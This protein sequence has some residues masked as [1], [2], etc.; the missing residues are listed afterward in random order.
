M[1]MFREPPQPKEL[2]PHQS[3]AIAMLRASLMAGKRKPVLQLSTGS[4][5]T[6]IAAK[7]IQSA[8][9]KGNR[10]LFVCDAIQLI[11]Q[12]VAAFAEEGIYDVGVIQSK[13][14]MTDWSQPVQ[15]ASIQTLV[16]RTPPPF[17]LCIIDEAHEIYEGH[18]KL[19]A[20]NPAARYIGLSA[21]PWTKGMGLVY[22]DL[23]KPVSVRELTDLGYVARIAA[24]APSHPD[25]SGVGVRA[26][27]YQEEQLSEI[28]RGEQLI[29][30]IVDTW[31]QL[32]EGRPTLGF[33]VDRAHAK[34]M[35]DR[36]DAAGIPCGYIDGTMEALERLEVRRELEAGRI[37]AVMSVGTMIKGVD[38]KFGTVIDAQPTKSHK[39][40]VQKLGRLRPFAEW[41]ESI[42]LD[43]SDNILRLGLPI[44]IDRDALCCAKKGERTEGGAEAR[45]ESKPKLC[46]NCNSVKCIGEKVCPCGHQWKLAGADIEEG[47]GTLAR[48]G[49]GASGPKKHEATMADKQAWFSQLR[50]VAMQRGRSD[51]WV[52]N[53]YREK[54]GVWPKG[55]DRISM[56]PSPEVI[57]WVRSKDIRWAKRK[58]T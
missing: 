38:W 55:L 58:K 2:R 45:A 42:V 23:I 11:D 32:G 8:R 17:D 14:P 46:P 54:F 19:M 5:K 37:A 52:S 56:D 39:R 57:G 20:G 13:H 44:D 10:V 22:D 36:F 34:A 41:P 31:K 7:I 28:M 9:A 35:Q 33:C 49:G 4:G 3:K 25:L 50:A 43:H 40:H 1:L 47:A 48:V 21:T 27:E 18:R 24:Y 12:T 6:L 51:G 16:N 53:A 15:V 29:A 30:D 26:G